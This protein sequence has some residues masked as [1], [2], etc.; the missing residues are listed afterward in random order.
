MSGL[1]PFMEAGRVMSLCGEPPPH[2][3]LPD[4]TATITI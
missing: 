2:A 4:E 3:E 1:L